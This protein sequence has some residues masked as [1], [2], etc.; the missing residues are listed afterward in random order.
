[1]DDGWRERE[2]RSLLGERRL[3]TWLCALLVAVTACGFVI[4]SVLTMI[5]GATGATVVVGRLHSLRV[6]ERLLSRD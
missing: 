2:R 6:A 3:L 1:M 4:A 5:A